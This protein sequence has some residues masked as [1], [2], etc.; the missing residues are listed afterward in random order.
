MSNHLTVRRT[1][2]YHDTCTLCSSLV[3]HPLDGQHRAVN[4]DGAQ[5]DS[6]QT[7]FNEYRNQRASGSVDAG[8]QLIYQSCIVFL[9]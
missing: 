9:R 3:P 4:R 6:I 2:L 1:V 5:T 7:Q 8:F